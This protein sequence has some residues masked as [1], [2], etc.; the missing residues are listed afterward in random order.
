[1][2]QFYVCPLRVQDP[3]L[4]HKIETKL[5]FGQIKS[6]GCSDDGFCLVVANTEKIQLFC[7]DYTN[8]FEQP[9]YDIKGK[10]WKWKPIEIQNIQGQEYIETLRMQPPYKHLVS[11][12]NKHI[13]FS[14]LLNHQAR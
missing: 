7:M 10:Q 9:D 12:I 5:P 4:S 3:L 6:M 11:S 13:A 14:H 1:M 2:A 8:I